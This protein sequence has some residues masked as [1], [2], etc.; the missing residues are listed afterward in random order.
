MASNLVSHQFKYLLKQLKSVISLAIH[1]CG[2]CKDMLSPITPIAY[3]GM[4]HKAFVMLLP[5]TV[6]LARVEYNADL[7]VTVC[8][9]VNSIQVWIWR[10]IGS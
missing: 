6:Y 7:L 4:K 5:H 3:R 9:S 10:M 1:A 8:I 2:C